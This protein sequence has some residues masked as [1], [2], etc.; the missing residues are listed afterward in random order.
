[1]RF[2]KN[3]RTC[4]MVFL[5]V[6]PRFGT[7]R[8]WQ[9]VRGPFGDQCRPT[10][11]DPSFRVTPSGFAA[12]TGAFREGAILNGHQ[13]LRYLGKAEQPDHEI[14]IGVKSVSPA[15]TSSICSRP[16][17]PTITKT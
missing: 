13:E 10:R 11:V 4:T 8:I 7:P 12:T 6:G 9:A 16:K 2:T 14:G 17:P 1:M 3:D 15:A 5:H